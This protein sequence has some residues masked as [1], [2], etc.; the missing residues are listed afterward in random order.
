M[1]FAEIMPIISELSDQG[2]NVHSEKFTGLEIDIET[3]QMQ[4]SEDI[5]TTFQSGESENQKEILELEEQIEVI[6]INTKSYLEPNQLNETRREK[7]K[8]V[9]K[10]VRK[11]QT[12]KNNI[13]KELCQKGKEYI[14]TRGKQVSAKT[15]V[16]KKD[17]NNKCKF[18]CGKQIG[19]N[20]RQKLFDYY[21]ELNQNEK[22]VFLKQVTE[23][24]VKGRKTTEGP[25]RRAYSFKYFFKVQE[26]R[27]QVCKSFFLGTLSI[28][29]K[30]IYTVHSVDRDTPKKDMR[31]KTGTRKLSS[32]NKQVVIDHINKFNVVESHYCR[33]KS[34]KKYLEATLT[35]PKMYDLYLTFC[36]ENGIE[37]PVK[38]SMYRHIF[39]TNFNYSFHKPKKDVCETCSTYYF[40]KKENR[41]ND[42]EGEAMERHI[43]EKQAMRRE[44]DNDKKSNVPIL[45]FDLE[46][47][48]TCPRSFVG[49]HFYLQ[50]LTMYNLTGHLSTTNKAYCA[51]WIETIQGRSGNCL[52][53]AFK[54]IIEK[55][56]ED[57]H[58]TEL[59]TWSDSCVPQNRNSHISFC[60]LDLLRNQ[61]DLQHLTMKYSIPGHGA[62][63]EVDNIHSQ[64]KK[65]MSQLQF[66]SPLGFIKELKQVNKKNPFV[67][68]L[69]K[70]SDFMNYGEC[71]KQ[72]KYDNI[73]FSKVSTIHFSK[74][75]LTE[76]SF[77]RSH[78]DNEFVKISIS[79]AVPGLPRRRSKKT[80][81]VKAP[82]E[83]AKL[84]PKILSNKKEIS[85]E[86]MDAIKK[87]CPQCRRLIKIFIKT[88]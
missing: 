42:I 23:R 68:I 69:M 45:C 51:L 10:K 35:I 87:C 13:R 47:V 4:C 12:W 44:K 72:M 57:N 25:S 67:T 76:V 56:L 83:I 2:I 40:K 62:V 19:E 14:N 43:A 74:S 27:I 66:F 46:N 80:A 32:E 73:P 85:Q 70:E 39:S 17:C 60:V 61:P 8:L 78:A 9:R 86:K 65:R 5:Q 24:Y 38:L 7:K 55:V 37:N 81:A 11:P 58:L 64:I 82:P 21:Y 29:Q 48:I 22:Y 84:I 28:S 77:K 34:Q 36:A 26:E 71:S 18:Q 6:E 54:K 15:I 31:G 75:D 49:N 16:N 30:P 63:Q 20:A 59:I 53:S 33:Q 41:L 79:P 52:A 3:T 88:Y 1:G 50:K